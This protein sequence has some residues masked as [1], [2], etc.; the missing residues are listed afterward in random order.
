MHFNSIVCVTLMR[1]N[2]KRNSH[3][4]QLLL[5]L[6]LLL[7][8]SVSAR[9]RLLALERVKDIVQ[10]GGPSRARPQQLANVQHDQIDG[11]CN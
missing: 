3:C 8:L 4:D 2:R 9:L 11:H 10:V 5:L 6:Q 1:C 7:V